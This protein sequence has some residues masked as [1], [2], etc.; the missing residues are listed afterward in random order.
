MRTIW[1]FPLKII[2][3][4]VITMPGIFLKG[5]R[6]VITKGNVLK[7]GV[8]NN[9]AFIWAMV[10]NDA[11]QVIR[12][13]HMIWTGGSCDCLYEDYI[14]TIVYDGLVYHVFAE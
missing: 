11:P 13:I 4:Q 3:T 7:V 12:M 1:K 6:D 9:E 5:D 8:M 10:D 14:G 2:E